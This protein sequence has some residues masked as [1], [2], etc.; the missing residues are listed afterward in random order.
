MKLIIISRLKRR[1]FVV[2][3]NL[4]KLNFCL[5]LY[6]DFES[7]DLCGF[8]IDLSAEFNWTRSNYTYSTNTGPSSDHTK[9]DGKCQLYLQFWG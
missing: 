8:T 5:A 2:Y 9:G 1:S 6:C 7:D 4:F 3:N